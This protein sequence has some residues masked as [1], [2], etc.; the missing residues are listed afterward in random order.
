MALRYHRPP[1]TS[2]Q[3]AVSAR[4]GTG[5]A[6]RADRNGGSRSLRAAR[7]I[8]YRLVTLQAERGG[9][10]LARFFGDKAVYDRGPALL[11]QES[12]V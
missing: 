3:L 4:V 9:E 11:E 7:E 2:D 12:D 6:G 10:A 1:T 5:I 8:E